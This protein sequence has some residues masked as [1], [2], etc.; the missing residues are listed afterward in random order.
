M[1]LLSNW[2]R[3]FLSSLRSRPGDSI[4]LKSRLTQTLSVDVQNDFR[5]TQSTTKTWEPVLPSRLKSPR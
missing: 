1:A 5:T 2:P 3:R 4:R